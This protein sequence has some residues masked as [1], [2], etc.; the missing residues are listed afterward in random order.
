MELGSWAH[1]A[2]R[3]FAAAGSRR[4][5]ADERR[6]V[7]AW[8][9]GEDE[10]AVYWEQ[11]TA[12]Q[13]HGLETARTIAASCPGRRDLVRAGLLHDIGKRHSKLGVIGR[14]FATFSGKLRLPLR[15][16]WRMYLD[17]G[18]LGADELMRLGSGELV[19][20]FA[21]HHHQTR[22][23]AIPSD[24]WEMLQRADR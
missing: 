6:E 9:S 8:L 24:D 23:V 7:E 10:E 11:P 19:V 18:S 21:R 20:E 14:S 16:S 15:R 1:L 13:R 22:P 17:H 12:D 3:F 4:L 5:T 2:R